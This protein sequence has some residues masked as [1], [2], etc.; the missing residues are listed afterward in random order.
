VSR[1]KY[2]HNNNENDEPMFTPM[3]MNEQNT[4]VILRRF[5]GIT[6]CAKCVHPFRL[7]LCVQEAR[8]QRD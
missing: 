7:W 2:G 3:L 6:F 8:S 4:I 5:L 1:G